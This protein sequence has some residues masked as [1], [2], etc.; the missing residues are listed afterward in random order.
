MAQTSTNRTPNVHL[1]FELDNE[2]DNDDGGDYDQGDGDSDGG[3]GQQLPWE[4]K[5]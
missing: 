5:L 2:G 4:S 3:D 1:K